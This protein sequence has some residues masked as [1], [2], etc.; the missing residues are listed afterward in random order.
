MKYYVNVHEYNRKTGSLS[1]LDETE[2][3]DTCE[4]AN[5]FFNDA[6]ANVYDRYVSRR[7]DDKSIIEIS[8]YSDDDEIDYLVAWEPIEEEK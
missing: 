6:Y 7:V 8:L 2:S 4:E 1:G 3:F 5:E